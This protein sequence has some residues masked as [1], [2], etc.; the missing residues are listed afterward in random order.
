MSNN[1]HYWFERTMTN[2]IEEIRRDVWYYKI[3]YD[4]NT[5]IVLVTGKDDYEACAIARLI[6]R[7][8]NDERRRAL[9]L[10]SKED[11]E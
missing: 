6:T 11:G 1:Q 8:L 9:A 5:T 3:G 2:D 7:T 4:D 10:A